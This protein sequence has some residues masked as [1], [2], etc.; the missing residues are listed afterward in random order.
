MTGRSR[1]LS[2]GRPWPGWEQAQLLPV[3]LDL[4]EDPTFDRVLGKA[5]A[6]VAAAGKHGGLRLE[7]V[8]EAAGGHMPSSQSVSSHPLYQAAFL[9]CA[10]GQPHADDVHEELERFM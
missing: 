7:Q 8:V 9:V 3:R 5:Q 10:H 4:A 2:Q 1:L 6:A